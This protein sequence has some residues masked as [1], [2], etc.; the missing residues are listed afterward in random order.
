MAGSFDGEICCT[1][2][3]DKTLKVFDVINFGEYLILASHQLNFRQCQCVYGA[4]FSSD[5]IN[6]FKLDYVPSVC[7]WVFSPGDP[8]ST[9]AMYTFHFP[10][11]SFLRFQQAYFFS[12]EKDSSKIYIYDGR[13]TKDA[14]K[15]LTT[16]HDKPVSIIRVRPQ[17]A[18]VLE[19]ILIG[20]ESL[21]FVSVQCFVQHSRIHGW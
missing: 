13:G 15:V 3:D 10:I 1:I 8:I 11:L 20:N 4:Y 2:A 9:V 5:M 21:N 7:C 18:T 17:L 12:S 14:L 16:L 6:M 19:S